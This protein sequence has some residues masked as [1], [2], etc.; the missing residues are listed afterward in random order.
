[1]KE[2][3]VAL[4][5]TLFPHLAIGRF[6]SESEELRL[7]A[8]GIYGDGLG[9][10]WYTLDA[11]AESRWCRVAIPRLL[12]SINPTPGRPRLRFQ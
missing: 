2:V 12:T 7:P 5:K 4:P 3:L 6:A 1:M 10:L 8:D 11:E 9:K